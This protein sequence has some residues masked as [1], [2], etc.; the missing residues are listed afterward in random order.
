MT[1]EALTPA[2]EEAQ[3]QIT[4]MFDPAH[5]QH[6]AAVAEKE[7]WYK[8]RYPEPGEERMAREVPLWITKAAAKYAAK[9][10]AAKAEFDAARLAGDH[11]RMAELG[12][13]LYPE[14]PRAVVAETYRA[15]ADVAKGTGMLGPRTAL[16]RVNAELA[17]GSHTERV[18]QG[19]LAER[20]QAQRQLYEAVEAAAGPGADLRPEDR[21]IN[22]LAS[23]PELT[24]AD[25]A[26]LDAVGLGA[27]DLGAPPDGRAWN[28]P[29]VAMLAEDLVGRHVV[30]EAVFQEWTRRGVALFNARPAEGG[31]VAPIRLDAAQRADLE[32]VMPDRMLRQHAVEFVEETGLAGE[33]AFTAHLAREAAVRRRERE[34]ARTLGTAL[35]RMNPGSK[36]YAIASTARLAH[37]QR[38]HEG[39]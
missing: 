7:R 15:T 37:Y 30:S 19:L 14:T 4:A 25:R 3:G 24:P 17:K 32:L 28:A 6:A 20:E 29:V 16:D 33:A 12:P 22:E 1:T 21:V 26:A 18:R 2:Q 10:D 13:T 31:S 35:A 38:A 11:A 23:K 8:Q 9:E 36:E 39:G 27:I 34:Q 5:P